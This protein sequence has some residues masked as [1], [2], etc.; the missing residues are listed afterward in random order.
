M[1][2]KIA[3]AA[4]MWTDG[5]AGPI[6]L[7]I[8]FDAPCPTKGPLF[9]R[10]FPAQNHRSE[11]N[12]TAHAF[13]LVESF[14]TSPRAFQLA[15]CFVSETLRTCLLILFGGRTKIVRRRSSTLEKTLCLPTL[16]E[17]LD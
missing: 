9:D 14:P 6:L 15:Q 17:F 10:Q 11:H 3:V 13:K 16:L 8:S 5:P 4:N 7:H 1:Q 2:Q 12:R